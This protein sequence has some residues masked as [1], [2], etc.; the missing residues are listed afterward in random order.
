MPHPGLCTFRKG[1]LGRELS[2]D[3]LLKRSLLD[4]HNLCD[5]HIMNND[6]VPRNKFIPGK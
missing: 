1:E 3:K 4:I 5:I 6:V 2:I